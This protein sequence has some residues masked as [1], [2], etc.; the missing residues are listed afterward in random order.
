MPFLV[1]FTSL[2]SKKLSVETFFTQSSRAGKL[3]PITVIL[4]TEESS[5][6]AIQGYSSISLELSKSCFCLRG[7]VCRI[8]FVLELDMWQPSGLVE[9]LTK[10]CCCNIS[11]VW[12]AGVALVIAGISQYVIVT[13]WS[14]SYGY[15][16]NPGI[17]LQICTDSN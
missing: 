6:L 5:V 15:L 4:V 3:V 13:H 2:P 16:S 8:K 7:S 11:G 1:F 10:C 12:F 17:S 9:A 14:F